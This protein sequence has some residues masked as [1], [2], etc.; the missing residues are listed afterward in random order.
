MRPR[1]MLL[2]AVALAVFLGAASY[3][4]RD[5]G[6]AIG[7]IKQEGGTALHPVYLDPGR[8]SY[9]LIATAA[10]VPPYRGD[11]AVALEGAPGMECAIH[12]GDPVVDLSPYRHPVFRG[13]RILGLE[14]RDK[15]ALWV[16]MKRRVAAGRAATEG[17]PADSGLACCDVPPE[18]AGP[19]PQVV[20]PAG[21]ARHGGEGAALVFRDTKTHRPVLHIPIVF[22]KDGGGHQRRAG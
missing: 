9:V 5:S 2:F 17:S 19:P 11:V 14:P 8:S 22:G 1:S 13:D 15:I 18:A 20:T 10:V 7:V 4:F 12:S 16:V 21:G 6:H 3:R